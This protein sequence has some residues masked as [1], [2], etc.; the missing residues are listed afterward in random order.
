L[1]E[2]LAHLA[3][4]NPRAI[5]L[6]I[7]LERA[8]NAS[9]VERVPALPPSDREQTVHYLGENLQVLQV[10]MVNWGKNARTPAPS[11]A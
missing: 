5:P 8:G 3:A 6:A 1:H 4:R 7:D 10:T 9:D 2:P 11:L